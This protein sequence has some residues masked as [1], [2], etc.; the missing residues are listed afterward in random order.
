[1]FAQFRVPA[2]TIRLTTTTIFF[3]C[4]YSLHFF[5]VHNNNCSISLFNRDLQTTIILFT[6]NMFS[7][8]TDWEFFLNSVAC[9]SLPF[10]SQLSS[11]INV[12]D[13]TSLPSRNLC[14]CKQVACSIVVA[15]LLVL[16]AFLYCTL[17]LLVYFLIPF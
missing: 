8:K 5:D 3:N 16:S 11:L 14:K 6:R 2:F 10:I 17:L 13:L 9:S 7:Y 15:C 12:L 1:M 4:Y